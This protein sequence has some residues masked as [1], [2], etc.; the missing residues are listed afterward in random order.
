MGL[1]VYRNKKIFYQVFEIS[2]NEVDYILHPLTHNIPLVGVGRWV[3]GTEGWSE[4]PQVI[5]LVRRQPDHT[6]VSAFPR[7]PPAALLT[8][9]ECRHHGNLHIPWI[10]NSPARNTS[11]IGI[12]PEHFLVVFSAAVW[13]LGKTLEPLITA[14]CGATVNKLEEQGLR[15]WG[16]Q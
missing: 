1:Q 4:L 16:Y 15:F 2:N 5:Q 10:S 12:F 11:G 9:N 8:G 13:G 6:P 14:L 3:Q 7:T